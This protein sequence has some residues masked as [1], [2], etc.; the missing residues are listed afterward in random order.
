MPDTL[1]RANL[2]V[3][4]PTGN[5]IYRTAARRNCDRGIQLAGISGHRL[6]RD[7]NVKNFLLDLVTK[8]PNMFFP[9]GLDVSVGV[10]WAAH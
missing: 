8:I 10:G 1:G 5:V 3:E 4:R 2:S 6:I 7:Y 9:G